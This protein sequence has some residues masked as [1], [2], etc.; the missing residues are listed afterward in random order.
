MT[1]AQNPSTLPVLNMTA[2]LELVDGD[3]EL[4]AML[5]DAFLTT[6]F[7]CATLD[8]YLAAQN[9]EEGARYVHA[10]K[11]AARQIGLERLAAAG[12]ALEDVL[13]GKATGDTAALTDAYT[14]AYDEAVRAVKDAQK[15]L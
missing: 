15:S 6:P 2:A 11:G 1:N 3:K 4:Y 8:G 12:Q 14:A 13:R 7:V 5:L 9:T 10:V